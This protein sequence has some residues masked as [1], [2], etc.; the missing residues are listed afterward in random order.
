MGTGSRLLVA[1]T[2]LA[3]CL[4]W[5]PAVLR[6]EAADRQ[7]PVALVTQVR[8]ADYAGDRPELRRL[9]GELAR[10]S[11]DRELAARVQYWRG[12][13]LWR[14]ALNGFNDNASKA[15]LQGDLKQAV[16]AFDKS[17][18]ADAGFVEAKIAVASC[19]G[20]LAY[21]LEAESP[22]RQQHIA[23]M[24][25]VLQ[26]AREAAPDNPR[27]LWVLGPVYWNIPAD[28][29][30]GQDKAIATYQSGLEIIGKQKGSTDVLEPLWGEPELRMSLAW[31]YLNR[32]TPDLKAAE[33]N[34]AAALQSVPEW[35]YVRDILIPQI[36]AAKAKQS[37]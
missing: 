17:L 4:T 34:A 35:H 25:Q 20:L 21:S 7:T 22:E 1:A 2:A 37:S 36:R 6:S 18:A 31:S 11:D 27:L 30:G 24:R 3:W 32:A 33:E 5:G 8:K 16:E 14:S 23:Q 12:F 10:F 29:G 15:E 9:Y 19:L 26:E 13:A 28:R